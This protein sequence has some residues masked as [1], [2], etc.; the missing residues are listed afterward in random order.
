MLY[1]IWCRTQDATVWGTEDAL[2]VSFTCR[3]QRDW[4]YIA[5]PH[6]PYAKATK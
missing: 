5:P 1:T 2:A 6:R 4:R 3:Y